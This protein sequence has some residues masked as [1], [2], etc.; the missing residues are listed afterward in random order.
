MSMPL[1]RAFLVG[2]AFTLVACG[3]SPPPPTSK[4]TTHTEKTTVHDT[5][6]TISSDVTETKTQQ[7]NGSEEV[8]RTEKTKTSAPPPA[9]PP[10]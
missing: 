7:P 8:E 2:T 9:A 4:T 3:G 6:E 1:F 10:K 5:G